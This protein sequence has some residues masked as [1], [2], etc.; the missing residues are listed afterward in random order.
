MRHSDMKRVLSLGIVACTLLACAGSRVHA[1]SFHFS[2]A[3]ITIEARPGEMVNR[4]LTLTLAGN[5][6]ATRFKVRTEDWW[7]SADNQRTFYAKPGTIARSCAPWCS[8]NPVESSVRPGETMTVKVSVRVPDDAKPG[9]YWAALTVDEV[10]DPARPNP[11]GVAMV[12][13]ASL[14]VGIYVIIPSA[15]RSARITGI[16]VNDGRAA[17]TLMNEGNT[18]LR[19]NAT[20]EFYKPGQEK[21][22]ATARVGGEPILPEPINTCTFSTALPG[23]DQLPAGRYRVRAIIDAELDHLMGAEKELDIL[24]PSQP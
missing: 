3:N 19:V 17:V 20:F 13:R 2:P 1:I 16:Q 24:R 7:R 21:P 18:P 8:V 23:P 11:Q 9:G 6:P 10:P 15:T 14:S 22:V 12:F 5:D 4:T